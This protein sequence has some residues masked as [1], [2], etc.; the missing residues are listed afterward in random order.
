MANKSG[1]KSGTEESELGAIVE[2]K[3]TKVNGDISIRRYSK[4]KFLGKGGFARC[5]EF[6]ALNSRKVTAA[7]IVQKA[8][9]T[10]TRA[11]QKLMSEI[12][13]HRSLHHPSIV[14]FEH[15]FEDA[16]NV[17]I[18]L[19]MCTNQTM[20]EL[21]RRRKRLTELEAQ[22]YL[23]QILSAVRY[24][25]QHRVIHRDLKLGNLFLT[26]KMEIKIGDFGL[27]TKLEFDGER[28]RTICGTPNYIA[29]EV[30]DGKSGHSYE[31]DVWAIGVILYTL[32]V[33][34][35]PFE[36]SDVKTTY[37]RIRM[38]AYTFP[39]N[40]PISE[41]AKSL[42]AR[43]LV[44]DPAKRPSI[45]D[46]LAHQFF[47]Q[48]NI[49]PKL[50]P[51]STLACPPSASYMKQFMQHVNPPSPRRLTETAP[52]SAL[53][54]A[55]ASSQAHFEVLNTDRIKLNRDL[56]PSDQPPAPLLLPEKPQT[57]VPSQPEVW[58]KKWVDYSSKYG[59]G[60]LLSNGCTGVYFNDS[61]KVLL[62]ANGHT[63][64]Y[65]ERKGPERQETT[66]TYTLTEY[67]KDLQKKVTLLQHFRSYL[68][69]D[70][71]QETGLLEPQQATETPVYIK[72]WMRTRHAILF[73]LTNKIVQ[74][75]FQDHTEIILSSESKTVTYVNK[76]GE[77]TNYP[78]A[79]ALE[80]S[81]AEMSK[82]LKYTKDILSQM[83][84]GGGTGMT[85]GR[86]KS[87]G[88]ERH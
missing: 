49:I 5:Y 60:Y 78:L 73:R 66:A 38:L 67:P 77:R 86:G 51:S 44:A 34:K 68:E 24:L 16:E 3:V 13:I 46:M 42:I 72:K 76:V 25:H 10:K 23:I 62:G 18:L 32:I 39:E 84:G 14:G 21:V 2:E 85:T 83:V 41:A 56:R 74:V 22:C 65:L 81:N 9:L 55:R 70:I 27:A 47:H 15:F 11:K 64:H 20:S 28:K 30:L 57:S 36:T 19:E 17:Y 35:P 50:L 80:S 58:V 82:R 71:K 31:V 88:T 52:T 12:K 26:E 40:V 75:N 29:P 53:G 1:R 33:G 4:G 69:G 61:S 48:G 6:V 79:T 45:D 43:I 7:K 63:L 37:R 54:T 59:L 8:S 87:P